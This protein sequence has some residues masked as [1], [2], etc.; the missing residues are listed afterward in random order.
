MRFDAWSRSELTDFHGSQTAAVSTLQRR[1]LVNYVSLPSSREFRPGKS[2][3]RMPPANRHRGYVSAAPHKDVFCLHIRERNRIG[4]LR[5]PSRN[6]TEDPLPVGPVNR[7]GKFARAPGIA[8]R[9]RP[10]P[11]RLRCNK[12][13]QIIELSSSLINHRVRSERKI[14]SSIT[15]S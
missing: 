4:G 11:A 9:R 3:N 2:E 7:R 14:E 13:M 15:A 12:R 6:P 10:D 8:P 5:P 1:D